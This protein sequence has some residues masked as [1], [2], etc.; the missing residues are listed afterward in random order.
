MGWATKK[1]KR[2]ELGQLKWTFLSI[3]MFAP[4]I[5]PFVMMSQASKSKVRSWYLL[6]WLLLFVQFGLFYSFYVFAGAMSQGMLLTVC[7]Y[8]SSYIIG[9][10]LLLNQSKSY[11]QRLELGEVRSLTW[12]NTLADQRRLELAQAQIE[13][14]QSFVTKLLYFQ[15]EVDNRNIQQYVDK[16]VRLFH[17]L[18]QRDIQEA[19][20]FLVRHGT[21]VN[22]LREYDD[23][24]NTRLNNQVTLD[25][26]NKL[27]AVLAQAATAIELDVTNLIKARLLDVSAESDVY[28]QTLKNKNLLKD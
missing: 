8:I 7:G 14:P 23:L 25:S 6:S 9:N 12:I 17:L 11:L 19:E 27:E 22:V 13:T 16:I 5:H 26:K 18:E 21:V 4:P 10:G 3:L 28:L 1:S 20:K 24:E 15:K 2:W